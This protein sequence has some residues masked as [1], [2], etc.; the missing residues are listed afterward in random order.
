[1]RLV[2]I[3]QKISMLKRT[4]LHFPIV[5]ALLSLLIMA[6]GSRFQRI[7]FAQEPREV[8]VI[9]PENAVEAARWNDD[10]TLVLSETWPPYELQVWNAT[11]GALVASLSYDDTAVQRYFNRSGSQALSWHSDNTVQIHDVM[12]GDRVIVLS[13]ESRVW[14]AYWSADETRI[15]STQESGVVQIWDALTGKIVFQLFKPNYGEHGVATKGL[16]RNGELLLVI[17]WLSEYVD[18][19]SMQTGEF[20]YRLEHEWLLDAAWNPA[21]TRILTLASDGTIKIWDSEHGEFEALLSQGD[22]P[23]I[24]GNASWSPDGSR[25]LARD[26]TYACMDGVCPFHI[27]SAE[28]GIKLMDVMSPLADDRNLVQAIWNP[29]GT[30]ILIQTSNNALF[31][32]DITG[33]EPLLVSDLSLAQNRVTIRNLEW[34]VT[35]LR[36]LAYSDNYSRSVTIWDV[37]TQTEIYEYHPDYTPIYLGVIGASWSADGTRILIWGDE[38]RVVELPQ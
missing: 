32:W 17:P 16:N 10:G 37:Q 30:Q 14:D 31:V 18:V 28:T 25:I 26:V 19:W 4:S 5:L 15:I 11:T 23:V 29:D 8:L 24:P 34:N 36:V 1:M 27:W 13:H 6:Q 12:S 7:S 35:G 9:Q 20:L 22:S 2:G 21:G 3:H 33:D 38:I